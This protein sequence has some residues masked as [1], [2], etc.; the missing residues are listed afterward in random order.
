MKTASR[1]VP[2]VKLPEDPVDL[3]QRLGWLLGEE[4]PQYVGLSD[5]TALDLLY[6]T[7]G[8]VR[9]AASLA[10]SRR[11][12]GTHGV[13]GC[14]QIC[15]TPPPAQAPTGPVRLQYEPHLAQRVYAVIAEVAQRGLHLD[16]EKA[17][18]MVELAEGLPRDAAANGRHLI[19]CSVKTIADVCEH[20]MHRNRKQGYSSWIPPVL[21][22]QGLYPQV[23]MNGANLG[24]L[25][26]RAYAKA[27][28]SRLPE[29]F[30]ARF[31]RVQAEGAV[32][33]PA[34]RGT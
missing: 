5:G 8:D 4:D 34:A 26:H 25:N 15:L 33:V 13:P 10:L 14:P 9:K 21:I 6:E 28:V 1:P 23:S 18:A 12:P 27:A 32:S 3:V 31:S 7:V 20:L 17:S 24:Y 16:Y 22:M 19:R 11:V 30:D 29:D 2:W